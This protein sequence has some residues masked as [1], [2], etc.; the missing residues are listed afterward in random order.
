MMTLLN[1]CVLAAFQ[2]SIVQFYVSSSISPDCESILTPP[3]IDFYRENGY[4]IVHDVFNQN[5]G[6]AELQS[7]YDSM[8]ERRISEGDTLEGKWKVEMNTSDYSSS[9]LLSIHDFH[10]HDSRFAKYIFFNQRLGCFLE[11]GT[12]SNN[13][14][15]HHTKAHLKPYS[16]GVPFP[17]HQ[18]FHYCLSFICFST[19]MICK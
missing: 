11:L 16:I 1:L 6:L 4:I 8:F 9:S 13:V 19:E 2:L 17:A 14:L 7:A 18:D 10:F 15:L 12:H 5:N 3:D